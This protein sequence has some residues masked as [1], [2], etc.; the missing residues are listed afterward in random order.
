MMLFRETCGPVALCISVLFSKLAPAQSFLRA[1]GLPD[2][3]EHGLVLHRSASGSIFLGGNIGDSALVQRIDGNG[4]V[5]WSHAFKVPGQEP[6]MVYQFADAF[7][8]TI[9]GCGNGISSLGEP[10]EAFHFKFSEDGVFHWVRR[11]DDPA[12][13]NRAIF[14]NGMNELLMLSCYYQAG[15][16][17][18]WTDYFQ[19]TIDQSTGAVNWVSD[20]QDLYDAV[21]YVDDATSA[22]R[23]NGEYYLTGRIYT[24]GSSAS[25]CRVNLTKVNG[26]GQHL[27]T[28]YL[29]FPNTEDHRMYGTDIISDNDSLMVSYY[30]NINGSS[31]IY[32]IGL[33]R[34]DTAGNVS[35]A[36]DYDIIGSSSELSTKV[37][38]TSFGYV[39]AGRTT[40]AGFQR[41]FLLAVSSYGDVLWCRVYG[42]DGTMHV[43]PHIYLK[44][45]LVLDDGFL[46]TGAEREGTDDDLLLARTDADG[47]ISCSDVADVV[48][49]TT[50]LPEQT[51]ETSTMAFPLA[52]RLAADVSQ[53]RWA[54]MTRECE[55]PL[56]LGPDTAA[57]G[58]VTLH[59][60][61]PGAA[62]VWQDGSTND[63]LV[64]DAP[65]MYWATATTGCCSRTDTVMV[66]L[67]ASG[68]PGGQHALVPNVFTPNADGSN[69]VFKVVDP[70][71]DRYELSVFDRWGERTFHSTDP[72]VFWDG[73]YQGRAVPDGTYYYLLR[74]IER[75]GEGSVVERSGHL[76]LLR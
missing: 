59:A 29:L 8:G 6:N 15:S 35:W 52:I 51:F 39:V 17:T 36:R 27:W 20:R 75:C 55:F 34:L 23:H 62:Y 16:G 66:T 11:W 47:M 3:Q 50:D 54:F 21:P 56:D 37:L 48:V 26:Q 74:Y 44:N 1:H 41:M 4:Q 68:D 22:V 71:P 64:V 45:L 69:D 46:F 19:S 13:Y 10:R 49:V 14:A 58:P 63:S 5:I 30:G 72:K 32:S 33:I 28:R 65:G 38:A 53:A 60:S 40:A 73:S 42:S 70:E 76:T 18:T 31:S 57:C 24:N 9:I 61:A 67:G 43:A 2:R 12:A 25:T 7:D